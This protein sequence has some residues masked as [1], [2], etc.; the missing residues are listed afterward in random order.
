MTAVPPDLRAADDPVAGSAAVRRGPVVHL[1]ASLVLA[2][3]VLALL[4]PFAGA[5]P[6]A[7]LTGSNAPFTDEGFNLA[8]ARN[9]VLFGRFGID[10][11][12]RSLTNGAY[13]A[14]A[15]AVFLV[16]RPRLAAGQV[17]SMACVAA[18]VLLLALGLAEPLGRPAALLAAA[19]LGGADLALEYGRLA[20]LEPMVVVLLTAAFVLAV[21]SHRHPSATAGAATGL[22]VAAAVSVKATALLPG[23][24][25][26][27][28]PLA[29]ALHARAS[30]GPG[31]PGPGADLPARLVTALAAVGAAGGAALVW[32]LAAALPNAD[33]LGTALRIWPKVRYPGSPGALVA[34]LGEY[35]AHSDQALGRSAPLLA[36]A[37]IGLAVAAARWRA[38]DPG[39]REAL[40]MAAGWGFGLWAAIAVGDYAPN[41]YVVPALPGLAV[42][43]GFG[44]AA[45]AAAVRSRSAV[46][47]GPVGT[48]SRAHIGTASHGPVGTASHAHI[49]TAF[50]G[51]RETASRG[52]AGTASRGPAG[53]ASRGPAGTAPRWAWPALGAR[54]RGLA[55]GVVAVLLGVA[56]A[57]PGAGRFLAGPGPGAGQRARDQR[58]LAALVPAG[59][60]VYGA[61]A[62]TLLF[63]TRLRLVTPWP[64][65]DANVRDPAGRLG[66]THV[67]A[68]GP[69]DPTRDVPALRAGT[70]LVPLA[71]VP[72]AGQA[73]WLYEIRPE[74]AGTTR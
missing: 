72:W 66:V 73:V 30:R 16:T 70:R 1:A 31:R 60:T 34:R 25:L 35:L 18:A 51:H 57:L 19:A 28:V 55:G 67:L 40:A 59:A 17:V 44:L 3:A 50:R 39:R 45:L 43:A 63:D 5:D 68:G 58:V 10:D 12:D 13:S 26:L 71:R 23:L 47:G 74:S 38:L 8:N 41:R 33:R 65:A 21:R 32:L 29:S 9:Q 11:V 2:A 46:S 20:L 4:L 61:Y 64:P 49:G 27:G 37:G 62:P 14:V 42:L 69:G 7:G 54:R 56:V 22:L 48:A 15:A 53:T 24:V 52:P 6:P 36:G